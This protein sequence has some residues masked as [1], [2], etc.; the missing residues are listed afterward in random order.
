MSDYV[1]RLVQRALA[2][3]TLLQPRLPSLFESGEGEA[4][5]APAV[6]AADPV[7]PRAPGPRAF[8]PQPAAAPE[9]AAIEREREREVVQVRAEPRALDP[10]ARV[11]QAAPVPAIAPAERTPSAPIRERSIAP[12]R[13]IETRDV[14]T[15]VENERTETLRTETLRTETL[16]TIERLVRTLPPRMRREHRTASSQQTPDVHITIGR[17]EVRAVAPAA[18]AET[19]RLVESRPLHRASPP[20]PMLSLEEYLRERSRRR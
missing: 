11:P 14:V 20:R 18:T 16:R 6:A 13:E 1:S 19:T 17:V 12:E 3:Q 5:A 9:P 7:Q 15:T 4:H 8:V 2:P 10:P